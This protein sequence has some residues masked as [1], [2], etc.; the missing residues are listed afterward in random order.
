[1][2]SFTWHELYPTGERAALARTG[3]DSPHKARYAMSTGTCAAQLDALRGAGLRLGTVHE[4]A[5]VVLSFDDGG[6]S[7]ALAGELL[8]ARG[9]RAHFFVCTGLVGRAGF[10]GPRALRALAA[11]GHAIGSHSRTHRALTGLGEQ[12]LRAELVRSKEELEQLLGQPCTA[13]SLPFGARSERVLRAAWEAGYQTVFTSALPDGGRG[14]VVGR[15]TVR[16]GWSPGLLRAL[17][18][19]EPLATAYVHGRYVGSA[20]LG[21]VGR[22]LPAGRGRPHPA[23]QG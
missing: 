14:P 15:Y 13:V 11:Q 10:L 1:M 22:W 5:D 8:Q 2:R 17:A 20:L 6:S 19:S 3:I 4:G 12:A 16:A 7:N 9:L 23:P 18:C 21:R